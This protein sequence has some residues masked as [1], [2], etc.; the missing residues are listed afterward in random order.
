MS[1][2]RMLI[3]KML[4]DGK[5]TPEEAEKLLRA[6]GGGPG[7]ERPPR[8]PRPPRGP[9]RPGEHEGDAKAIFKGIGKVFDEFG[10]IVA[11]FVGHVKDSVSGV[12]DILSGTEGL[13]I[14]D[15][16]AE[17]RLILKHGGGSINIHSA[18]GQQLVIDGAKRSCKVNVDEATIDI[19]SL[20][21]QLDIGIPQVIIDVEV[22]A[23]G[24]NFNIENLSLD[25]LSAKIAGGNLSIAN[26]SGK[27]TASVIGGT[28]QMEG[29]QSEKLE[30]KSAG[31]GIRLN[32]G[33]VTS[34]EI[35]LS[36]AGGHI[37]MTV[38]RDSA[39]EVDASMVGGQF[40]SGLELEIIES[41]PGHT[42]AKYND[43]GAS[44][45]LSSKG[46]NVKI[47]AAD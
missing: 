46:G 8:P 19:T 43:G 39:F 2:E 27:I 34:G 29:V 23:G 11:D 10:N 7:E 13:Q 5:I 36:S 16:P 1:E 28:I 33:T 25:G 42:K 21:G 14:V 30:A 35:T 47:K 44:I 24:G 41:S 18:E 4:S 6:I 17:S 26:S 32:M 31:G 20:G 38:A 3:L 37:E 45:S 12:S 40:E 9:G 15:V 22:K